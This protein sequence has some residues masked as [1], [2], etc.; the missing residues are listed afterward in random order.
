VRSYAFAV[1]SGRMK[2]D[3]INPLL[4]EA[5]ENEVAAAGEDQLQRAR[6]SAYGTSFPQ[7]TKRVFSAGW[8]FSCDAAF[9]L[10]VACQVSFPA[11]RDPR[12]EMREAVVS[13]INYEQGCNPVNVDYLAGLGSR[14]QRE[15]VHKY[16]QNDRRVLPPTGIPVGNVQGGFGWN[17][18]YNDALDKL[19]F[20]SDASKSDPFPFYDRWGDGFNLSQEFVILNQAKALAVTCWLMAET[21]LKTQAWRAATAKFQPG[22]GKDFELKSEGVDLNKARIVWEASRQNP[23]FGNTRSS[24]SSPVDWCEAEAELPDGRRIF[25]VWPAAQ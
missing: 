8:Y 14:R 17:F 2:T 19:S 7:E 4:L 11:Q 10:A 9:D 18:V 5:C 1:R 12:P 21:S 24:F 13:N 15:I 20:P 25:A 22:A 6:Q 16:A 3:E 23:A